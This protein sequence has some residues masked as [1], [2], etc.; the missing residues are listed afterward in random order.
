MD[1]LESYRVLTQVIRGFDIRAIFFPVDVVPFGDVWDERQQL[2]AAR[3]RIVFSRPLRSITGIVVEAHQ[4]WE[5]GVMLNRREILGCA[6]AAALARWSRAMSATAFRAAG[7]F[8]KSQYP[9]AMVSDALGDVGDPALPE[10]APLTPRGLADA[11]E[12]GLTAINLTINDV[13]NGP[14]KFMTTV[15]NIAQAE[16]ELTAHPEFLLKILRGADLQSAKA[17]R[18]LGI[19]YQIARLR[20]TLQRSKLA[21]T[22]NPMESYSR[23]APVLPSLTC[24]KERTPRRR[25]RLK[26]ARV[27]RR[28]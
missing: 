8:S 10:D 1:P 7:E 28:A 11:R 20:S 17:T 14:N 22:V 4:T 27:R 18:R 19:I 26:S 3:R 24:R 13:G 21:R 25:C 15:T 12:S 5:G 9:H 16:H 23:R 2:K 6:A